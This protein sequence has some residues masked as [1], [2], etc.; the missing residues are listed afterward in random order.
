MDK[1]NEATAYNLDEI[2]RHLAQ[3]YANAQFALRYGATKEALLSQIEEA[4]EFHEDALGKEGWL[5]ITPAL[6]RKQQEKRR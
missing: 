1:P 2:S 6:Q 5:I 4:V 3:V